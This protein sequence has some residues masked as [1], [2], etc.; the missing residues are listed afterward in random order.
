VDV[1][2]ARLQRTAV[3]TEAKL[4]QLTYAFETLGAGSGRPD[5]GVP[6]RHTRLPDGH[7]RDTVYYSILATSGP[8]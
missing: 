5:E 6:R 3:N 2:P 4:F 1:D 8:R 7:I